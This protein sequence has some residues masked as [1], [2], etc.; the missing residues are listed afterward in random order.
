MSRRSRRCGVAAIVALGAIAF[1]VSACSG[2]SD[3]TASGPGAD[4][5]TTSVAP[6]PVTLTDGP[7]ADVVIEDA[8]RFDTFLELVGVAG[9]TD[10]VRLGGPWTLFAPDDAAL[11]TLGASVIDELRTDP[12]AARTFVLAHVVAGVWRSADLETLDGQTLTSEAATTLSFTVTDSVVN[13]SGEPE[14]VVT[15]EPL[16]LE[17]ANAV[18][19]AVERPLPRPA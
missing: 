13:I 14:G 6:S 4:S 16:G 10:T 15:V 9:L 7:G 8:G 1:V 12:D 19:H 3:T 17:A 18:V 5:T 2:D 11:E